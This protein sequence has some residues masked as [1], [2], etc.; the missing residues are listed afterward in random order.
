M[1][2]KPSRDSIWH[3]QLEISD[4]KNENSS[5]YCEILVV[6]FNPTHNASCAPAENLNRAWK[7][8][9]VVVSGSRNCSMLPNYL[10]IWHIRSESDYSSAFC[11]LA[12]LLA[13][14]YGLALSNLQPFSRRGRNGISRNS[15]IN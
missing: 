13:V 12:L 2:Q 7:K 14:M 3:I 5:T 10:S 8:R 4:E 11:A 6:L 9:V 1:M 15:A